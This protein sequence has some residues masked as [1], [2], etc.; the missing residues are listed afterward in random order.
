MVLCTLE[1]LGGKKN[2]ASLVHGI[3]KQLPI[4]DGET[5]ELGSAK[6]EANLSTDSAGYF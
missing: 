4:Q 6:P 3:F 1:H 5:P 2:T